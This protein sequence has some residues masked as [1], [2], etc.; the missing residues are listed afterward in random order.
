MERIRKISHKGKEI[1]FVDYSD[2]KNEAEM[3]SILKAHKDMVLGE[4]SRFIFCADYTGSVKPSEYALEANKF[5]SDLEHLIIKGSFIGVTGIKNILLTS[6]ITLFGLN[7]K[8]FNEK[9]SA[10]DYLVN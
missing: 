10:L 7:F 3:I 4:N 6:V 5:L 8:T 9:N 1:I 2:V